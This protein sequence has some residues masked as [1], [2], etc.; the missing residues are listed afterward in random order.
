MRRRTERETE[1]GESEYTNERKRRVCRGPGERRREK[2]GS[3][4]A[5]GSMAPSRFFSLLSAT[6]SSYPPGA[7][8]ADILRIYSSAYCKEAEAVLHQNGTVQIS[9]S[10]RERTSWPS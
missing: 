5:T 8:G 2:R 4:K 9:R 3:E 7:H 10:K 6:G 1:E